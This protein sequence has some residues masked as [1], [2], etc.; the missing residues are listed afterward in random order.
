MAK[1]DLQQLYNELLLFGLNP[2]EWVIEP[3][4]NQT[5]ELYNIEDPDFRMKGA[6]QNASWEKI[7]LTLEHW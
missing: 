6:V 5:L 1:K 7:W 2:N 3:S 4:Q